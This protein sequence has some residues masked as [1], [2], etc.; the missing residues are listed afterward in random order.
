[1]APSVQGL[2]KVTG[3]VLGEGGRYLFLVSAR[4]CPEHQGHNP[5]PTGPWVSAVA[6]TR[7]HTAFS[8]HLHFRQ[9]EIHVASSPKVHRFSWED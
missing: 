5:S 1:M 3:D 4:N 8:K 2:L 6:H 7:N 9:A